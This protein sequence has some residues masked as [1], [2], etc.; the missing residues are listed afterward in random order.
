MHLTN[1]VFQYIMSAQT[2]EIH[3]RTTIYNGVSET[4][5]A[6]NTQTLAHCPPAGVA[7]RPVTGSPLEAPGA[8]A[9][10]GRGE[11]ARAKLQVTGAAPGCDCPTVTLL[12]RSP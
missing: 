2:I 9:G 5:P 11:G 1:P 8:P 6:H 3:S 7:H 4:S 12:Y 10:R